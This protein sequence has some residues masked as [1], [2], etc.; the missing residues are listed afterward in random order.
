MIE[1]LKPISGNHSIS[2]VS[3]KVFIPQEIIKP[4]DI[5]NSLKNEEGFKKYQKRSPVYSKT[6]NLNYDAN[7]STLLGKNENDKVKGFIFE[8]FNEEGRLANILRIEN[9]HNNKSVITFESRIYEDWDDFYPRLKGDLKIV[10]NCLDVYIEAINLGYLDE[11]I[12]DSEERIDVQLI[13]NKDS[14]L[15]NKKFLNS[16]NGSIILFSQGSDGDTNDNFEERTEISFGNRIKRI[17]VNHQN[18]IRI[19]EL[20]LLSSHLNNSILD[21]KFKN[22]QNLNKTV[23]KSLFTQEVLDLINLK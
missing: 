5:F 15:I 14:E 19:N 7:Q 9:T 8:E 21:T 16:E 20:D 6:I 2:K 12:W 18:A 22:S 11:F 23:L 17:V 4:E 3:A 1:H 13:F 10:S